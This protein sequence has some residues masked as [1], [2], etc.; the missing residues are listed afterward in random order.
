MTAVRASLA[1]GEETPNLDDSPAKSIGLVLNLSDELTQPNIR[2]SES[3]TPIL[4]HTLNV[5][6]FHANKR[7]GRRN[8]VT[9]LVV[10]VCS[11]V[12]RAIMESFESA[13]GF[14]SCLLGAVT[15]LLTT[16]QGTTQLAQPVELTA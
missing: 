1:A 12:S 7:I 13:F 4:D 14:P 10:G 16:R 8:G 6:V 3:Q 11:L 9:C 5:Q 15:P 2:N